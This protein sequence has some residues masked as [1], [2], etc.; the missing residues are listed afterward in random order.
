MMNVAD[1][2]KLDIDAELKRR[3]KESFRAF[4]ALVNPRFVFY[5]HCDLLAD[6]I[7]RITSGELKR[8]MVFLPPRHSK[9]EM[10]SRL[11]SA[12]YLLRNPH[13]FVGISSYSAELA[14]TLSRAARENF[15]EAGGEI[16]DEA[17]AVKHWETS[18]KGG[19]WAAG[20]GGPITGKGYHCFPA[21]T[22]VHTEQG[23]MDIATL[24]RLIVRPKV[25]SYNHLTGKTEWREVKAAASQITDKRLYE[26][27]TAE[28]RAV[29]A[30]A[31]HPIYVVGRGYQQAASI[32]PG[33]KLFFSPEQG[34]SSLRRRE[35][36]SRNA[37]Q[38]VLLSASQESGRTEMLPLR[39]EVYAGR[40][41][42]P[43]VNRFG[44]QGILLRPRMLTEASRREKPPQMPDLRKTDINQDEPLLFAAMPAALSGLADS[45][46]DHVR[47]LRRDVQ[48][49][50]QNSSLLRQKMRKRSSFKSYGRLRQFKLSGK[51]KLFNLV[52]QNEAYDLGARQSAVR[53]LSKE[54]RV[55]RDRRRTS[56]VDPAGSSYKRR[57]NEQQ[58][59]KSRDALRALPSKSSQIHTDTVSM[60]RQL[61]DAGV[62]VYD[63]EV[64]GNHNFFANEILVH[65][66]GIIDDPLKNSEDASSEIIR[67]K[68][69]EWYA[70]TFYTRQEPDAAIVVIQTRWNEDDLSGHL[71][72]EE[73]QG[74][75]PENW[76]IV[77][78][79]A[80]AEEAPH[81]PE[82]C[83][84]EPDIRAYGEALCPERYSSAKLNKMRS[85][86]G[87][88]YFD[89]L[90]QQRPTAK[91]GLFFHVDKLEI[92]D[93]LPVGLRFARG[94]DMAATAGSGD[95]TAGVKIGKGS[96]GIFYVA[97]VRKGQMDTATRDRTIR[98][99]AEI[100]G[101]EC[102]QIGEQEPG[103][104]GKS[105]AGGFMR[106]LAGFAV[107][108]EPS[109]TKK[110]VRADPFSSQVNAG[111]VKILRGEWNRDYI[112]ELRSFP[113]GRHDDQVDGG[114][115]AFNFLTETTQWKQRDFRI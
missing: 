27:T 39:K 74:E 43:E 67:N 16:S 57:S 80:I 35:K 61:R 84:L 34:L 37:L 66:C 9:S 106:L 63:I 112:E 49:T 4:V 109:T 40:G 77:C 19:L 15:L 78:L 111:N 70:S 65:N 2:T 26:I 68:Q 30:T 62:T 87:E 23:A 29:T 8:V 73:M 92:V 101:R 21:G 36:R 13:H 58:P 71:L 97:D 42:T 90:Y 7:E 81:I 17:A 83:T 55:S 6:V 20:V 48:T 100:D 45:Y 22:L 114:S 18:E 46:A 3:A 108:T 115:L 86:I 38:R 113:H 25:L 94:W 88:Y 89:S 110:D 102:H 60:V 93:A 98:Q 1:I 44:M 76:H 14:Y 41:I 28:G 103:S 52:S 96:D 79:P 33:D 50:S 99:T 54:E 95:Y 31:D 82:T 64:E 47:N 107:S 5:P 53:G 24:Y 69:K 32:R 72:N 85:R 104:G 51:G 91:Q 105:A 56:T 59:G 12:Y 10:F 11:F 75:E